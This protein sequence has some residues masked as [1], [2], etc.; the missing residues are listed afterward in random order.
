[1]SQSACFFNCLNGSLNANQVRVYFVFFLFI[2]QELFLKLVFSGDEKISLSSQRNRY[3]QSIEH[4]FQGIVGPA[5]SPI[6]IS[7][8]NE[9]IAVSHLLKRILLINKLIQRR[10]DSHSSSFGLQLLRKLIEH[11][12]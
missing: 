1:M 2:S 8:R 4:S 9:N 11:V 6:G 3:A 5:M 12:E 7:I 10:K